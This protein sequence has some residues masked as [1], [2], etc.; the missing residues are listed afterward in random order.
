MSLHDGLP[1]QFDITIHMELVG[2]VARGRSVQIVSCRLGG[3][4]A[5]VQED[6][7]PNISREALSTVVRTVL[8]GF[9]VKPP[10]RG[11]SRELWLGFAVHLHIQKEERDKMV[12]N[13]WCRVRYGANWLLPPS[14]SCD[15]WVSSPR[16]SLMLIT[17]HLEVPVVKP[18]VLAPFEEVRQSV[19]PLKGSI[20]V[21][22]QTDPVLDR[23]GIPVADGR[24]V[25]TVEAPVLLACSHGK[26]YWS[27]DYLHCQPCLIENPVTSLTIIRSE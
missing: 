22:G 12:I 2:R 9:A 3:W 19:L 27:D 20:D 23:L 17:T 18:V 10:D 25:L 14:S 8:C 26:F 5:V 16:V 1:D 24:V 7:T 13:N 11:L 6:R 21:V 15:V 4:S